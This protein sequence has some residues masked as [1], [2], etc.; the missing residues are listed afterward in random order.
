M[1]YWSKKIIKIFASVLVVIMVG[2]QATS[3]FALTAKEKERDAKIA[4][5]AEAKAK[6]DQKAKEAQQIQQQITSVQSQID[7]TSNAL[8]GTVSQISSTDKS[9]NDLTSQI[10]Q[11]EDELALQKENLGN[12]IASW[13]MEGQDGLFTAILSSSA[14]SDIISQ[15]QYYDSVKQQVLNTMDQI[16]KMRDDLAAQKTDKENKMRELSDLKKQQEGYKKT[17]EDQKSQKDRLLAMTVSQKADYLATV[18]KLNKEITQISAEIYA[19]RQR[20]KN[21]E[22]WVYGTSAYPYTDIDVPDNW[23]FLTRECTSYVA[24]YWNVKLGKEFVNTRPGQGSAWNWPALAHDQGYS[25]SNTPKVGAIITWQ[26][27]HMMPYG[28]VAI[29]EGVNSDGT[30]DLSEYNWSRYSYTYRE[31]VNPGDYGSYS[32]IY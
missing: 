30:I 7:Q 13:Y 18:D 17:V 27:S 24:W 15:Q 32:Y 28:H 10:K 22:V 16:N 14:V 21:K 23:M 5:Q 6:A 12:V 19:E 2:N 25:V 4:Q 3:V 11:K 26:S 29:V 20:S 9:I 31:N 8:N 1:G